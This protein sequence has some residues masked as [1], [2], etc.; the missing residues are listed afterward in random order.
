MNQERQLVRLDKAEWFK[1]SLATWLLVL[2]IPMVGWF[3]K[4]MVD[5]NYMFHHDAAITLEA[6]STRIT[7]LEAQVL[8]IM[9]GQLRIE[10]KLDSIESLLRIRP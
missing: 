9:E 4:R 1:G 5:D 3:L 8:A 7:R 2:L 6:H 10:R